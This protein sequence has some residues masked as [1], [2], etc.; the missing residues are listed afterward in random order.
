L[1]MGNLALLLAQFVP[2]RAVTLLKYVE[3]GWVLCYSP[4]QEG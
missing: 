4:P 3:K 2:V 1:E